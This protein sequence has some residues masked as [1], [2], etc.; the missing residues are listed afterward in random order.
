MTFV[1]SGILQI[2]LMSQKCVNFC[3]L[4]LQICL[5]WG[6]TEQYLT[7]WLYSIFKFNKLP[8][9]DI[10]PQP[11]KIANDKKHA[12]K[13]SHFYLS[14]ASTHDS[15]T[16]DPRFSF[17]RKHKVCVSK[18]AS[19]IFSFR[20]CFVFIKVCLFVQQK[21]WIFDFET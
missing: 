20:F 4:H 16:F 9:K 19:G 3:S 18:Y 5:V 17:E 12:V 8:M 2:S 1:S 6:Y 14:R 13:K 11:K 21:A 10:T 15:F 7:F